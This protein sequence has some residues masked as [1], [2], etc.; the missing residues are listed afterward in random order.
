MAKLDVKALA[1]ACGILW[2]GCL[3]LLGLMS[4]FLN[5]GSPLISILSSL[6]IGYK[7]SLTGCL[8]GAL[9]G[10]IDAGIGGLILGWLYNKLAR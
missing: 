10:F 3:F 2:G 9:W 4:L 5:W 6:Y 7:S 8:I 1:L